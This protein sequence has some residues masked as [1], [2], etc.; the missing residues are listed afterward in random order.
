M[1]VEKFN[2]F[3]KLLKT[4]R[5]GW[6]VPF[7]L[8]VKGENPSAQIRAIFTG[9]CIPIFAILAFLYVWSTS[10]SMIVTMR[11]SSSTACLMM[12]LATTSSSSAADNRRGA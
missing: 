1:N 9:V 10:S 4:I 11:S 3:I 12:P 2:K 6:I 8:L 7:I 5:L